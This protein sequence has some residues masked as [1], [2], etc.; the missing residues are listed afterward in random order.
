V[1]RRVIFLGGFRLPWMAGVLYLQ[2]QNKVPW[3]RSFIRTKALV[4]APALK[5][6]PPSMA[7]D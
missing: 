1:A 7:V 4:I 6:L 2:E 5:V 3:F